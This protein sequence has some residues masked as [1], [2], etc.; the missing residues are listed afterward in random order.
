MNELLVLRV[1]LLENDL[2]NFH[3]FFHQLLMLWI[4]HVVLSLMLSF[5]S[6][7]GL[8]VLCFH[9]FCDRNQML[10]VFRFSHP[11]STLPHHRLQNCA[12]SVPDLQSTNHRLASN[13]PDFSSRFVRLENHAE[14]GYLTP[15]DLT[16]DL[17]RSAFTGSIDSARSQPFLLLQLLRLLKLLKAFQGS[18]SVCC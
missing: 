17:W 7:S 11:S 6:T 10:P 14:I 3:N 8:T 18:W 16:P 13:F 12:S 1:V 15:F 9:K 4:N 2:D 5:V